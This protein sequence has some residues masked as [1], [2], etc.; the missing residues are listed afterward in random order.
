[1]RTASD[2][3]RGVLH[4]L[5]EESTS[6]LTPSEFNYFIKVTQLQWFQSRYFAFE[7]NQKHIDD[8]EVLLVLTD[9][10]GGNPQPLINQG[11]AA[12]GRE[13]FTFPLDTAGNS[14]KM[15]LVT[16]QFKMKAHPCYKGLS[17]LLNAKLKKTDNIANN[18]AYDRPSDNKLFYIQSNG[19]IFRYDNTGVSTSIAEQAVVAYLRK[20]REIIVDDLGNS[21]SN[22]EFDERVNVEL[23]KWC[24]RAFLETIESPRQGSF[25]AEQAGVNNLLGPN[26]KR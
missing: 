14:E 21:V 13:Y 2:M 5:K 4:E 17:P 11:S 16:V 10:T 22:P 19:K 18:N 24:V 8:L 23:V 26:Q 6:S 15:F 25:A 12:T 9:G 3:Y 1:M 7:E 20:P